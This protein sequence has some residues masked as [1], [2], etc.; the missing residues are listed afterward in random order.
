MPPPRD[1]SVTMEDGPAAG[2]RVLRLAGPV[3]LET[4]FKFRDAI[5]K[6]EAAHLVLDFTQVP[7][8]DS[9]GLGSLISASVRYQDAGRQLTLVAMNDK[10]KALLKMTRLESNFQLCATLDEAL[11]PR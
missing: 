11:R 6:E 7:F 2:Q 8:L 3:V 4:L 9:A 1:L 10:C 5:N